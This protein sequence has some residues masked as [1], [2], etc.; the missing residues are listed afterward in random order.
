MTILYEV[1]MAYLTIVIWLLWSDEQREII[2]KS[3][4]NRDIDPIF[5]KKWTDDR[6]E[7]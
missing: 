3:T 5:Y 2:G 6:P 1:V 4:P 7:L